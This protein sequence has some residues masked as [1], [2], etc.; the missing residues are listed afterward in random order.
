[1]IFNELNNKS[2]YNVNYW[3]AFGY[4]GS[5][6]TYTTSGLLHKPLYVY[7]KNSNITIS[8]YQIYNEKIYDLLNKNKSLIF[9]KTDT[10]FV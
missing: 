9:Y 4:T 2:N 7:H 8:A 1:M 5:G 6:K 10:L 3:I